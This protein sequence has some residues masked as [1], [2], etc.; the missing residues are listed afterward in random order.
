MFTRRKKALLKS[1]TDSNDI[2]TISCLPLKN[3]RVEKVLTLS[4]FWI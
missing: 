1:S 4:T 3:V 2:R